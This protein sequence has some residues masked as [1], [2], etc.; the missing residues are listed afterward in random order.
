MP[1]HRMG[2]N[3]PVRMNRKESKFVSQGFC[4]ERRLEQ[5]M[6][7]DVR[8]AACEYRL[9]KSLDAKQQ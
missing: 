6:M 4:R 3:V 9:T 8:R 5:V 2:R 7:G 1:N